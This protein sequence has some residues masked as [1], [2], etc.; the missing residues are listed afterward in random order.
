MGTGSIHETTLATRR[1]LAAGTQSATSI[2]TVATVAAA[3]DSSTTVASR[4]AIFAS[5][6]DPAF[7]LAARA[8]RAAVATIGTRISALPT[9]PGVRRKVSGGAIS[10]LAAIGRANA[11]A[12]VATVGGGASRSAGRSRRGVA[13]KSVITIRMVAI[14]I[15]PE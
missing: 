15:L 12:T 14:A 5:Q 8:A 9:S 7:P 13:G 2:A 6:E 10:T 1:A 3:V 4:G 11:I